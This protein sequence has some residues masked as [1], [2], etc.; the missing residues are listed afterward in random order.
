MVFE[1]WKCYE[2]KSNLWSLVCLRYLQMF[3]K[4]KG[5]EKRCAVVV[6]RRTTTASFYFLPLGGIEHIFSRKYSLIW[7]SDAVQHTGAKTHRYCLMCNRIGSEVVTVD[8]M[9]FT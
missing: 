9:W 4:F 6:W 8:R 1:K 5:G 7:F 2:R 3:D